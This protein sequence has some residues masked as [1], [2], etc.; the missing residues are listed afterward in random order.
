M[1]GEKSV[2]KLCVSGDRFRQINYVK[3][4]NLCLFRRV[5][6]GKVR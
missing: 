4:G 1:Q 6:Q 2:E 3:Y 5:V